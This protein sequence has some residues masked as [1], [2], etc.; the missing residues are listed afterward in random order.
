MVQI[1][2][3]KSINRRELSKLSAAQAAGTGAADADDAEQTNTFGANLSATFELRRSGRIV[4]RVEGAPPVHCRS[5]KAPSPGNGSLIDE[6][7]RRPKGKR[8]TVAEAVYIFK[9]IVHLGSVA[10]FGLHSWKSY[11]VALAMD[12]FSL[13]AY[14][15]N[16]AALSREQQIELSRRQFQMLLYLMRSPFFERHTR[17]KVTALV[18]GIARTIPMTKPLC[19]ALNDYIPHWQSTYFYMWS[20]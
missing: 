15:K 10:S 14:Y 5:W 2:A 11:C 12:A 13:R 8:L 6:R 7:L 17:A 3:T 9:P 16:R 18:D 20:S 1:P 19:T 4:R